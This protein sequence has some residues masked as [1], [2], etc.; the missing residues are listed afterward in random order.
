MQA[1]VKSHKNAGKLDAGKCHEG[2]CYAGKYHPT[3]FIGKLLWNT[4]K[5]TDI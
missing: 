3:N 1:S 4:D 2:K 5:E